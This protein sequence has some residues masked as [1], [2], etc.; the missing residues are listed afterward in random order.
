MS[1]KCF[2]PADRVQPLDAVC[3]ADDEDPDA[4]VQL[5]PE[6]IYDPED[7]PDPQLVRERFLAG[8]KLSRNLGP[9]RPLGGEGLHEKD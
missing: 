7:M 6:P 5:M 3:H 1:C 4:D 8:K 2:H 9:L